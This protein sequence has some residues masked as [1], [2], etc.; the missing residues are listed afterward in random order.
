[1]ATRPIRCP[2]AART[3][4]AAFGDELNQLHQDARVLSQTFDD[5]SEAAPG[6]WTRPIFT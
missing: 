6:W 4:T 2:M 1:M 5:M 3:S